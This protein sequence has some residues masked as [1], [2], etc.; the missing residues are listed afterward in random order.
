M[1]SPGIA[2]SAGAPDP[3]ATEDTTDVVVKLGGTTLDGEAAAR[4]TDLKLETSLGA[5]AQLTLQLAAWNEDAGDLLWVDDALFAPGGTVDVELGYLGNR[6]VVFHGDI[7]ELELDVATTS[8]VLTVTARD[9]LHR[10]GRGQRSEVY[11]NK[12]YAGVVRDL[13]KRR[14][15]QVDAPDDTAR[16]PEHASVHQQNRSDLE[17]VLGLAAEIDYELYAD[18]ATLV[19]R[20]SH[21]HDQQAQITLAADRDLVQLRATLAAAGQLGGVDVRILDTETKQVLTASEDNP[22]A[23]DARYG[24]ARRVI[25][26]DALTKQEQV[27]ARAKAELTAMRNSFLDV[28]GSCLGRTDLRP[29]LVLELDARLGKRFGGLYVVQSVSHTVSAT[30]GFRTGFTLKGQPR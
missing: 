10:L 11:Q 30:G 26:V 9:L 20:A 18:G 19:F 13:A 27:A 3:S 14:N 29:G 28:T 5:A 1:A 12:T 21:A 16:D 24:D 23:A 25:V 4:V 15:L 22:D 2:R 8:A 17:F 7:V 6:G